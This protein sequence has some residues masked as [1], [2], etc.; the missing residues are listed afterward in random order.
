MGLLSL[1]QEDILALRSRT[2]LLGGRNKPMLLSSTTV[3]AT[4][5]EWVQTHHSGE[6]WHP[7]LPN[8]LL[9]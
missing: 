9:T 4:A 2:R 6:G 5:H 3:Q 1:C 8:W 7:D